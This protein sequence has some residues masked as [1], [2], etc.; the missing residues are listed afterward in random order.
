LGCVSLDRRPSEFLPNTVTA[1]LAIVACLATMSGCQGGS[2]SIRATLAA[3]EASWQR[4]MRALKAQHAALRERFER[5]AAVAPG[6]SRVRTTLKG[7]G[8]SL[9]DVEIQMREAGPR[10]E[11]ALGRG[12]DEATKLLDQENL[13]INGYLQA[14]AANLTSAGQQLDEFGRNERNERTTGAEVE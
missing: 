1:F 4:D 8:Q 9:V 5:Q 7:L 10:V 6:G 14:L 13:Q 12:G 11:Q 2:D 3:Q